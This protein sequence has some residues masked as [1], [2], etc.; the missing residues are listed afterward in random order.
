MKN[1]LKVLFVEDSAD[2]RLVFG[3]LL[4]ELG[5]TVTCLS[6]AEEAI[7]ALKGGDFDVLFTDVRL[8]AMSGLE[9]SAKA[10][11]QLPQLKVIIASGYGRE[12]DT[13]KLGRSV[14]VL[15]KPYDIA[16]VT[17]IFSEILNSSAN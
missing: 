16:E 1:G 12:L 3:E 17:R 10:V 9:L 6:N 2:V 15:P 8:P 5:H 4:G 13:H 14:T 7:A 11:A